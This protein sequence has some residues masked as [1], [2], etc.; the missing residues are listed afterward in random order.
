[1]T[2]SNFMDDYL[3]SVKQLHFQMCERE[4]NVKTVRK[5]VKVLE[6]VAEEMEEKETGAGFGMENTVS[7]EG[8]ED[9]GVGEKKEKRGGRIWIR[10]EGGGREEG[11]RKKEGEW[12]KEGEKREEERRKERRR[13]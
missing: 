2:V 6:E 12:R 10:E 9:G 13:K 3:E 1:M 4:V 5:S 7:L 11:G 8:R